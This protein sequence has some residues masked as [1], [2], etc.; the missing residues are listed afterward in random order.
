MIHLRLQINNPFNKDCARLNDW[1]F[2]DWKLSKN[3]NL[4]IQFGNTTN[5]V[6]VADIEIDTKWIGQDHAGLTFS[7]TI[8]WLYLIIKLYDRRHWNYD[9]KMWEVE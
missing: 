4:E 2:H 1:F 6:D 5:L 9:D 3:K 7:L 8:L